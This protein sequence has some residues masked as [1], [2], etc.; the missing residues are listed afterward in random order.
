M[1]PIKIDHGMP[2]PPAKR[3]RGYEP[4][5]DAYRRG[6]ALGKMHRYMARAANY[7]GIDSFTEGYHDGYNGVANKYAGQ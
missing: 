5:P 1:A 2:P 7:S 6:Y 3:G 4:D